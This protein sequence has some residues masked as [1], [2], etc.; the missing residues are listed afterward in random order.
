MNVAIQNVDVPQVASGQSTGATMR[1]KVV[2]CTKG[3]EPGDLIYKVSISSY[4][5]RSLLIYFT[6]NIKGRIHRYR[7]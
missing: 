3:F 4:L 5:Q 7:S 1:K 6:C 2:V